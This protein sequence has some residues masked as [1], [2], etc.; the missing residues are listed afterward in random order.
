MDAS[1]VLQPSDSPLNEVALLVAGSVERLDAL[2]RGIVGDHGFSA[3]LAHEAAQVVAIVC[4]I[5]QAKGRRRQPSEQ[6]VR[7]RCVAALPRGKRKG[8]HPAVA[9][10]DQMDLGAA[11]AAGPTYGLGVGPPF[12][13][14]AERC[15]LAVVLSISCKPPGVASIRRASIPCQMPRPDQRW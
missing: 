14:E 6:S 13:P 2:A 10:R 1:P 7:G 12:P 9:I 3:S 11:P 8:E 5:G 15:A 4:G